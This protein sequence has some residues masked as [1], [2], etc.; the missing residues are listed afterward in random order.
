MEHDFK[1]VFSQKN[2]TRYFNKFGPESHIKFMILVK[3]LQVLVEKKNFEAASIFLHFINNYLYLTSIDDFWVRLYYP[4]FPASQ[5]A[6]RRFIRYISD[7]IN[8]AELPNEIS[9]TASYKRRERKR[10]SKWRSFSDDEHENAFLISHLEPPEIY[11]GYSSDIIGTE[12]LLISCGCNAPCNHWNGNYEED[13]WRKFGMEGVDIILSGYDAHHNIYRDTRRE[14]KIMNDKNDK[15]KSKKI[16][17]N[18]KNYRKSAASGVKI[19][20]DFDFTL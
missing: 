13:R 7:K 1:I 8:I 16:K 14:N 9:K 5:A 18:R 2:V 19:V 10:R 4:H 20:D 11:W 17:L 12:K 3:K 15:K 6:E